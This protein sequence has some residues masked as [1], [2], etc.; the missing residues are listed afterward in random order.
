M[1][2]NTQP[3]QR[4]SISGFDFT[5]PSISEKTVR[6]KDVLK[7]R[8]MGTHPNLADGLWSILLKEMSSDLSKEKRSTRTASA[9]PISP[10]LMKPS[11]AVRKRA[12]SRSRRISP[13]PWYIIR[14]DRYASMGSLGCIVRIKLLFSLTFTIYLR[15]LDVNSSARFC[16]DT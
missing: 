2:K 8:V 10:I 5:R 3:L 12:F 14:I 1:V 13:P 9:S 7:N 11:V 16:C 15:N 6:G 4:R